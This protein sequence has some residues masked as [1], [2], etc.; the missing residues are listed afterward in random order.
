[1]RRIGECQDADEFFEALKEVV[2][3][4][5]VTSVALVV[6][7]SDNEGRCYQFNCDDDDFK[8]LGHVLGCALENWDMP[9]IS[10]H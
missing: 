7:F 10:H 6:M 5:E 3:T 2:R 4:E 8:A 1:M 9:V